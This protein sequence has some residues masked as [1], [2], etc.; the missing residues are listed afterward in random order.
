MQ[1]GKTTSTSRGPVAATKQE[2]QWPAGPPPGSPAPD[3]R[4]TRLDGG[5]VQ[6]SS[7]K[8][9]VLVITFGSYTS[10]AFRQRVAQLEELKKSAGA[11]VQF[12]TV[13]TREAHPQGQWDVVRNKD[14]KIA[15]AQHADLADREKLARLAKE[16]LSITGAI[17]L[18]SM[19]DALIKSYG[20]FPNGS[21]IIS[22]DG[23][24]AARQ[25]WTDPTGLRR[26]IDEAL[27]P[28]ALQR[29]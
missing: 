12:L 11:G 7:F 10:P 13:Y 20:G 25:T 1:S 3:F 23:K 28:N 16:K 8:G 17:A 15:F 6:L 5:I 29:D 4:L 26:L 21:V 14:D 19:E 2:L 24:I 18:D 27:Q 9:K 22:R